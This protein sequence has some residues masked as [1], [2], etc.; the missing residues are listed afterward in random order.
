MELWF[1]WY[2]KD[3]YCA[4]D[5]QFLAHLIERMDGIFPYIQDLLYPRPIRSQKF[6]LSPSITTS[7]SLTKGSVSNRDRLAEGAPLSYGCVITI[8]YRRV[9]NRK[10]S[11]LG[12]P[13]FNLITPVSRLRSPVGSAASINQA[14][15]SWCNCGAIWCSFGAVKSAGSATGV[16]IS[17]ITA[18]AF[19]CKPLF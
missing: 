14:F 9:W 18:A 15:D 10:I 6:N 16:V 13:D 7:Q 3:G 11:L 4:L 8:F 2:G 5:G 19:S 1:K 12:T 17:S